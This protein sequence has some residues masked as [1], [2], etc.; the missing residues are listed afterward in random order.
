[1]NGVAY[2]LL[3][4]KNMLRTFK[5]TLVCYFLA[6]DGFDIRAKTVTVASGSTIVRTDS[7]LK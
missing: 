3:R 7:C 1:M 6:S 4:K 5:M 2:Q